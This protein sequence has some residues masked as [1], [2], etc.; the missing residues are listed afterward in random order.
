MGVFAPS[1]A[2]LVHRCGPAATVTG[3][4][5]LVT[6]GGLLRAIAPGIAPVLALTV[7]YESGRASRAPSC[8]PS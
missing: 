4:L 1:A 3:G 7:V 6:G 8:R 2:R 5:V